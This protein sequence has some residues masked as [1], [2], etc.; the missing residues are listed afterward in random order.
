MIRLTLHVLAQKRRHG[1]GELVFRLA[2][3]L[4]LRGEEHHQPQ[5]VSTAEDRRRHGHR[6]LAVRV[7]E[8]D[9]LRPARVLI[10]APPLH[11]LRRLR[12]EGLSHQL[13][14]AAPRDG[15]HR[16]PVGDGC[17]KVRAAAE[18]VAELR[19]KVLQPA[20]EGILL[21]NDL[22][23]TRRVNLQRVALADTHGSSDFLRDNDAAEVV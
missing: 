2:W 11:Q 13:A 22:P 6:E 17:G 21:K 16:I 7:G 1:L 19:R 14:L 18:R 4:P 8:H 23:V 3:H 9:L 5:H 20:D 15:H 12:R 10:D